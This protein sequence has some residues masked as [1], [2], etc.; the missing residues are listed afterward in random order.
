MLFQQRHAERI[1]PATK[2]AQKIE[3]LQM[4]FHSSVLH[5][6]EIKDLINKTKENIDILLHQF[7]QLVRTFSKRFI[8]KKLIN[9]I[10]N[11]RQWGAKIM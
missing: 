8:G 3:R 6:T 11:Q 10:C 1:V 4:E 2:T 7:Q 5:F 9:R